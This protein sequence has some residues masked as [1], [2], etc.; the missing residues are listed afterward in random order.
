[1]WLEASGAATS[2]GCTGISNFTSYLH[3]DFGVITVKGAC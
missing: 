3:W 2:A 1:M